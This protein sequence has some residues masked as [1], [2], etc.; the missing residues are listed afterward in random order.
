MR[1]ETLTVNLL[2]PFCPTP[3]RHMR[4]EKLDAL[5]TEY[6]PRHSRSRR[7]NTLEKLRVALPVPDVSEDDHPSAASGGYGIDTRNAQSENNEG[8]QKENRRDGAQGNPVSADGCAGDFSDG[9]HHQDR[10][11]GGPLDKVDDDDK[12][13]DRCGETGV[14]VNEVDRSGEG[15]VSASERATECRRHLEGYGRDSQGRCQSPECQPSGQS[16]EPLQGK[17]G[18]GA[19]SDG[20]AGV[21]ADPLIGPPPSSVENRPGVTGDNEKE[22]ND[23]GGAGGGQEQ[24]GRAVSAD[25]RKRP[26]TSQRKVEWKV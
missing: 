11:E 14:G 23:D 3:I 24:G 19:I 25:P 26:A 22:K 2:S 4:N 15:G 13:I 17:E 12:G 16:S 21:V 7:N 1:Y 5:M 6:N 18:G 20:A 10:L 9:D 8:R